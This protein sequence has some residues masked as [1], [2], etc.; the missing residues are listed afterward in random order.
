M[1]LLHFCALARAPFKTEVF[2]L[3]NQPVLN[4]ISR[5]Q[6]RVDRLKPRKLYFWPKSEYV[7]NY[8][9]FCRSFTV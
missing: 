2:D 7:Q 1:K 4:I 8:K 3:P 9:Y 6:I 5:F